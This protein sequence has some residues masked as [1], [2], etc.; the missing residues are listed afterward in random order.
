[1]AV[2][3]SGGEENEASLSQYKEDS[4][5]LQKLD[6]NRLTVS[7]F[8]GGLSFA[9]FATFAVAQVPRSPLLGSSE[10][11]FVSELVTFLLAA[12]TVLFLLTAYAAYTSIRLVSHKSLKK[13][14]E[15][16]P[17]T[18]SEEST[19]DAMSPEDDFRK[20]LDDF[21]KALDIHHGA[22]GLIT[23]GLITL[24]SA[25]LFIALEINVGV[26]ILAFAILVILIS[27]RLFDLVHVGWDDLKNT[28]RS[29]YRRG[30]RVSEARGRTGS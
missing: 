8:L 27:L 19:I 20:G 5:T 9:A 26:F 15:R 2:N 23:W 12:S 14:D 3:A 21:R 13:L 16:Y 28:L 4:E 7:S 18:H 25:L 22:N 17:N 10:Q 29:V 6:Q 24:V 11:L 30:R 1:M